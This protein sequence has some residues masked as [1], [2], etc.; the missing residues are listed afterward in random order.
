MAAKNNAT[1]RLSIPVAD[2][3]AWI[4]ATHLKPQAGIFAS[5]GK[6]TIVKDPGTNDPV[7]L[8]VQ[9]ATSTDAPPTSPP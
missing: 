3:M 9:Y 7:S 2:V 4:L 5:F 1:G 8:D 6:M